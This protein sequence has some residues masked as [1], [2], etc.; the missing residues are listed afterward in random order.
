MTESRPTRSVLSREWFLYAIT[1]VLTSVLAFLSLELWRAKLSVPLTYSGDA[2]PT[3]AHFKT[4]IQEGWYEYQPRL[5]APWGQTYNDF[6]TAD[7]LHMVFAKIFGLF[8]SDWAAALNVYFFLGFVLIALASVWFLRVC[9]VS[10][11]FS[12][13][14][15]VVFA[16]APYHFIRGES[17]LWLA[18]YYGVPLGL[19]LLVLIYKRKALWGKGPQTSAILAWLFGPTARTVVFL[20]ILGSSSSYYSVF[21]LILLAAMGIAVFVRD[22]EWRAFWG[23]VAAGGVTVF[24]M[25]SKDRKSVV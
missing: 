16:L 22:R 18:S 24:V 11:V 10:R 13:V 17:H 6:P 8:S 15:S 4:V 2:L 19:G 9:G 7:N 1:T 14:L 5:G 23:A 3:A 25:L 21:F 20:A 12:V